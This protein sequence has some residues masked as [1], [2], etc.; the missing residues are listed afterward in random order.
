MG[1]GG[2]RGLCSLANYNVAYEEASLN[3]VSDFRSFV[4]CALF[5]KTSF[6]NVIFQNLGHVY[7]M[8]CN[9]RKKGLM[10]F[11]DNAGPDEPAHS[12]LRFKNIKN[13]KLT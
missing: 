3:R 11:V 8:M 7:K 6:Y 13:I 2:G 5:P 12:S 9:A 1:R 10:Q 4:E